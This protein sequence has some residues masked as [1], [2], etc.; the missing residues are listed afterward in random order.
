MPASSVLLEDQALSSFFVVFGNAR[1]Y[2][3]KMPLLR[4]GAKTW[5]P[6]L[7]RIS[8]ARLREPERP[9]LIVQP[10]QNRPV[11]WRKG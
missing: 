11:Q 2:R 9:N 10:D 4:I 1:P 8:E 6:V 3:S 7:L 5:C